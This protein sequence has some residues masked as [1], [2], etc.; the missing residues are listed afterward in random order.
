M[1]MNLSEKQHEETKC[2]HCKKEVTVGFKIEDK[3][4]VSYDVREMGNEVEYSFV[5]EVECP[6][7]S[8]EFEIEGSVWIY[9][10]EV[11][12]LIQIR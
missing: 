8:K 1:S 4:A 9:P 6:L 5:S 10:E 12:N 3:E 2:P 11:I 7:C